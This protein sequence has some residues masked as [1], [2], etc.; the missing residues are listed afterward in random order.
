MAVTYVP[1]SWPRSEIIE[2]QKEIQERPFLCLFCEFCQKNEDFRRAWAQT[3]DEFILATPIKQ[4]CPFSG[5]DS[6]AAGAP[7]FRR[8]DVHGSSKVPGELDSLCSVEFSPSIARIRTPSPE[9]DSQVVA[10]LQ[11]FPTHAGGTGSLRAYLRMS[12]IYLTT[13]LLQAFWAQWVT[14]ADDDTMETWKA[15]LTG[16]DALAD[17]STEEDALTDAP[18]DVATWGFG[19]MPYTSH[20]ENALRRIGYMMS[21]L[22]RQGYAEKKEKNEAPDRSEKKKRPSCKLRNR[23]LII[24]SVAPSSTTTTSAASATL[25]SASWTNSVDSMWQMD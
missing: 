23:P 3:D 24:G 17:D 13:K 9:S 11:L 15:Y 21:Q 7:K 19:K 8:D 4:I 16:E 2:S 5:H 22:E 12:E 10:L 25:S 18:T 20:R 6:G 14:R 1:R